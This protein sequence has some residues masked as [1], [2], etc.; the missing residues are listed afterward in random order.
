[1]VLNSGNSYTLSQMV[2]VGA[3]PMNSPLL[4]TK[5]YI[6]LHRFAL[7][8]RDRLIQRLNRD[9]DSKLILICALAGFGKT[10][11][12]SEWSRQATIPV[13][14]LSLDEADNDPTRFWA[15]FVTAIQQL[16]S[17]V[18]E[19]TLSMLRSM[20]PASFELYLIPLM[21]ALTELEHDL[22]LSSR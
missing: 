8:K 18:G 16:H 15:Y 12:L 4:L 13:S 10:T 11:L 1:M 9:I 2:L 20:E 3:L 5:F 17:Q 19:S 7:V 14:W 21:N 6:P 22:V